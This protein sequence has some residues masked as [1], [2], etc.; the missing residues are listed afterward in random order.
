MLVA[1]FPAK[2]QELF[3][4]HR[5]KVVY[6]GRGGAKSWGIARAILLRAAS[7]KTRVVCGR[8]HMASIRE[9]VYKLLC[10][11]IEVLGL[12][13]AFEIQANRIVGHN[14]SEIS[15]HGLRHNIANIK[16]L[17]G[18]DIVWI[19]E[20]DNVSHE[21]WQTLTPTVRKEGS[22]IWVSFNP[23]LETDAT[24]VRFVLRPP[25]SAWVQRVGWQDNPWFPTVLE[26]ER[27][28][29]LASDPVAYA[30]VWD[31]A[32]LPALVGAV[33]AKELANA[34]IQAVPYYPGK[35]VHRFWDLGW[36]DKVS[37]WYAQSVGL[38]FRV[39]RYSEG[40]HRTISD[41]IREGQTYGYV[42]GTD[43][44]PH[45]GAAKTLAADG[46]S[47][48]QKMRALG[49]TVRIVPNL[50]VLDGI[51]AVREF[52]P[53]AYFDAELCA[54]GIEAV[55]HYRWE[56][57]S[58]KRAPLHDWASHAAD[59]LR[60]MALAVTEEKPVTAPKLP[61]FRVPTNWMST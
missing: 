54:D 42:Y 50:A 41:Y 48:E 61:T 10:D 31:G 56:P 24:Y 60:M 16:S 17:E 38:E 36:S 37:I 52:F 3:R 23:Q 43:W 53:R 20:A 26:E 11:Q 34:R 7:G 40:Q 32:C 57:K 39:I 8:E 2:L 19:E 6:G 15:F 18:A 30:H 59:A 49:C 47:I 13:A 4:P 45:D 44:L 14:G 22:E 21:T 51:H 5:Y 27:L 55:R 25:A 28:A 9:S 58:E 46:N 35:P 1:Q 12:S 29:L 33:Y